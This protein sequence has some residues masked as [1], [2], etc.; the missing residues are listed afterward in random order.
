MPLVHL[1]EQDGKPWI[2]NDNLRFHWKTLRPDVLRDIEI[3]K[4]SVPEK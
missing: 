4:K 1:S 2:E 3:A